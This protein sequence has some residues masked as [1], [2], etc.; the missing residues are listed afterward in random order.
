MKQNARQ[1]VAVVAVALSL[2]G[3]TAAWAQLMGLAAPL[4][5]RFV[6][7]FEAYDVQKA[8]GLNTLTVYIEKEEL[9]FNVAE[10]YTTEGRDPAGMILSHLFPPQLYF[11]GVPHRLDPLKDSANRGKKITVEGFLYFGDNLF[12]VMAVKIG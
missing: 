2:V 6:G 5:A 3:A 11:S 4:N 10:I 7:T 1:L 9:L 12:T 8:G